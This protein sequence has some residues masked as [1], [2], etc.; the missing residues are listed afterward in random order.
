MEEENRGSESPTWAVIP[1]KKK[2]RKLKCLLEEHEEMGKGH[3]NMEKSIV[4]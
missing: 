3:K 1:L 4:G 2:W